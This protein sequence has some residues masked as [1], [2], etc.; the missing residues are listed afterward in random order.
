MNILQ[1]NIA[2][3]SRNIADSVLE[4]SESAFNFMIKKSADYA[5]DIGNPIWPSSAQWKRTIVVIG[6]DIILDTSNIIGVNDGVPRALVAFKDHDGNGGNIIISDKVKQ[7]YAFLYAEGSIFSGEKV[8]GVINPYVASGAL[9]IPARQLYIKWLLI[10]KN[11]IGWAQQVPT[12]CPVVINECTVANSQIY[13][14]N[15][16][17]TY[18]VSDP[19]QKSTPI[20]L[21][22]PRLDDAPL[23]IDYDAS[24][25]SDPPPG[26]V[27]T[28]Q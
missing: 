26:V 5:F 19:T 25:L 15:Y 28:I 3:L 11:T 1:K 6:K 2:L 8:A 10:S 22:D 16:F 23:I 7:I 13:D 9:N 21:I 20:G 14:L 4:N 18:D 27:S 12:V 17:R 24:I